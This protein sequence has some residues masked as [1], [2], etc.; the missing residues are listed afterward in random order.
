MCIIIFK[1][2]FYMRK[3]SNCKVICRNQERGT[4]QFYLLVGAEEFYLFSTRYY[5]KKIY[6]EFSGGKPLDIIFRNSRDTHRQKIQERIILMLRYLE[7]EHSMQLLEKTKLKAQKKQKK[8]TDTAA[9]CA[10]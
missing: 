4:M 3:N 9:L 8:Y 10:A 2:G 6:Q 5:S 1:G 7:A